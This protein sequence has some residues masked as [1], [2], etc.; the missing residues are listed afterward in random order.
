MAMLLPFRFHVVELVVL[1]ALY[2]AHRTMHA[3]ARQNRM[4]GWALITLALVTLWPFG[5][6]AATVSI[7][8]A[9][10]QRL[11][12]MLLVAPLFLLSTP[13]P[14][15]S[16]VTRPAP[17]D[18]VVRRLTHP[19]VAL[20]IVTIVG[21][22]TLS[23]AVVNA[24]A[25][26]S[27]VHDATLVLIMLI[28]LILWMPALA[29]M[30]GTKRL[31]PAARAG[32]L[33][34]SSLVVTSLSFVWIF[35]THSLYSALHHQRE[36]LHITPL[37]DQQLAGFLA[38]LGAYIPMWV[39]AFVIFFRAEEQGQPV[40]ETPLHWA[41]VERHLERADRRR[42]RARRRERPH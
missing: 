13:T 4:A 23:S 20:A 28:G 27:L 39:V 21:T 35:S 1:L 30:P 31:S 17:I 38:K 40:E 41:D 18:F 11:V 15:L 12:I 24:G 34:A 22:V 25:R 10:I 8:A 32:F 37:L 5:D 26:S 42:S 3:T 14:V 16:R 19:G 7:T 9:T 2:A 33:I 29:I 36:L 6:L